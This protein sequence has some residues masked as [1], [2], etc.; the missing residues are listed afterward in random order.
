EHFSEA[1][2]HY[3]ES[4]RRNPS[5]PDRAKVL[6]DLAE[7]LVKLNQF[8]EA[9]EV[10]HD[11][12]RSAQT[13]TLAAESAKGLGKTL[14]A[15]DHLREALELD[16]SYLPARLEWG[17]LQLLLHRTK[18]AVDV[19]EEAVRQAPYSSQAHYLLSNAFRKLGKHD[20][21]DV[22]LR[23]FHEAQTVEREFFELHETASQNPRDAEVRYRLGTLAGKLAKPELGLM[24]FRAA[25]AINPNHSRAR[26]A[27]D[28]TETA[29]SAPAP[30]V[31]PPG[32]GFVP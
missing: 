25:L 27:V 9:L 15:E 16:A 29:P 1:I 18:E 10:L 19:L 24:W 28:E 20:E 17:A 13:L 11:C 3:R 23:L 31:Q 2:V 32:S 8:D 22:E 4:L 14:E 12:D 21:A 5:Q 6:C 30:L 26:A 7:S